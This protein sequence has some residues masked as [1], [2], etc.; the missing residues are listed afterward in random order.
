MRSNPFIRFGKFALL[1]LIVSCVCAMILPPI[2]TADQ[3][4]PGLTVPPNSDGVSFVDNY[5]WSAL[6]SIVANPLTSSNSTDQVECSNFTA[7]GPCALN[8]NGTSGTSPHYSRY[9]RRGLRPIVLPL[10][11]LAPRLIHWSRVPSFLPQTTRQHREI[12]RW[13]YRADPAC[14]CGPIPLPILARPIRTRRL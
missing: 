14:S 9:V 11:H 4:S 1:T 8:S 6:S 2:A 5:Q 12:R 3:W 13:E 10:W 7:T